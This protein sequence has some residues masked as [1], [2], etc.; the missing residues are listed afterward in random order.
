M[1]RRARASCRMITMSLP[2]R[3]G[4]LRR[5]ELIGTGGFASV[6]RY[7]DDTLRSSVAVK[8]LADNWAQRMDVRERF[9]T[10]AR[11]LRRADSDHVVRV[12]D[13]GEID[14]TPYFVMTY[15]S[16]G[17]IDTLL[18]QDEPL[19]PARVAELIS[20]VGL[21]LD[22]LHR[23]GVVHR[24]IKPQNLL[25]DV[26]PGGATK[27]L[28]ADLGLAK[29]NLHA[30]GLTE[31]VG[32]PAYMAPEQARGSGID[33]RAD[34][35]ALAA[36]AYQMLTGRYARKDLESV[37]VGAPVTPPS[38]YSPLSAAVDDVLLRAL[39]R[40]PQRRWAGA[41]QFTAALSEAI[42]TAAQTATGTR[43]V[44]S[45]AALRATATGLDAGGDEVGEDFSAFGRARAKH[46]RV[47][48]VATLILLT[49]FGG[50]YLLVGALLN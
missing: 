7:R 23:H 21:G 41:P 29:A 26:D 30:S 12:Y 5:V 38:E 31:V 18:K 4:R 2:E 3:L 33:Q 9:L 43:W 25:L 8:A 34:V 44:P 13:I 19:P 47:I 45:P 20:Q 46:V 16:L 28:V 15:A 50:A 35:H 22:V 27:V 39:D 37:A 10:E 48:L 14:H 42:D 1:E 24:D 36:V 40:D 6:W 11:I 32:T 17:T 49:T